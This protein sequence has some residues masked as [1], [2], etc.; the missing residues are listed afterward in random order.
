MI[1]R[2]KN[3]MRKSKRVWFAHPRPDTLVRLHLGCGQDYW[4][5]YVNVDMD[6]ASLCDIRM[7]FTRIGERYPHDSVTEI[8]LIHSLSYLRLW[9]ARDL[10]TELYRILEPGGRV[11][12]EV[13]DFAKCAQKALGCEGD[14]SEYL[15]AVRGLYA[16][17]M[18][19]I[20]RR[21]AFTPYAFAWS[22]WHLKQELE[23]VGFRQVTVCD[24]L[25]HERRAWRDTRLEAVK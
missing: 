10:F 5:G 3:W 24:P 13:P 19:Q 9:Q 4:P 25:T 2:V 23:K 12:F 7:D 18:D 8:A 16:F 1:V 17:G 15:E 11:I 20:D 14:L 6:T 22:S 21:E